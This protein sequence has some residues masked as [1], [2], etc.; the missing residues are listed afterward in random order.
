MFEE[1]SNQNMKNRGR[2]IFD[3]QVV[4]EKQSPFSRAAQNE[5]VKELY[6]MGLFAPANAEPALVCLDAMEFEGKESIKQQIQENSLLM[7][8][9]QRMQQVIMQADAMLPQLQLAAQA[10]LSEPQAQQQPQAVASRSKEEGTAEERA[11]KNDTDSTLA[12]K[13]RTKAAKQ[14]QVG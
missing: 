13:A 6:G 10:G 7:Q 8:Q 2:S 1:Y 14:A 12:A 4:A 11:A 3:I 5:T 9:V